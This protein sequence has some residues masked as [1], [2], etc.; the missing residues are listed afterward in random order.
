MQQLHD[1]IIPQW[2][3]PANVRAITTTRV[4]GFSEGQYTSMNLG[5]RTDDNM[6][7]IARNRNHLV[8]LLALPEEPCWLFQ[9]HSNKVVRLYDDTPPNQHGDASYST[10]ADKVC[11][12]LTADCLPVLLCARDGSAV[13]AVHAGWRGLA[14]G[15]IDNTISTLLHF[16]KCKPENLLAWLGPA[17]GPGVFEVGQDVV[18][19]CCTQLPHAKTAFTPI[20]GDDKWLADIYLLARQRLQRMGV[21]DIYGGG[22]CTVNQY[23]KFYSYRRDKETGRMATLIWMQDS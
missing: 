4:G 11:V 2:P 5:D 13:A 23:E 14:N 16:G 3:A 20:P 10:V 7:A 18:D 6:I 17:I 19:A 8:K 9:S 15:V 22:F 12:V 1:W 21:S